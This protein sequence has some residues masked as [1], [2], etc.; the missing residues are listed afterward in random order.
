MSFPPPQSSS[1]HLSQQSTP[2]NSRTGSPTRIHQQQLHHQMQQQQ[3]RTNSQRT[4][5]RTNR[6]P[7]D[8]ETPPPQQQQTIMQSQQ[9]P[10]ADIIKSYNEEVSLFIVFKYLFFYSLREIK[11]VVSPLTNIKI[12]NK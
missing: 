9:Q 6:R 5:V 4:N 3:L 10:S 2:G 12:I 11:R 7:S 8:A 1:P